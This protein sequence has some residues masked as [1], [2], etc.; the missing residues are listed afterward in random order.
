MLKTIRKILLKPERTIH[1]PPFVFEPSLEAADKNL[2]VLKAHNTSLETV[3][4]SS[5]FSVC[6]LGSEFRPVNDLQEIFK[7]HPKL[8]KGA[9]YPM[10]ELDEVKRRRRRHKT[11]KSLWS[12][13][14]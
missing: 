3:L 7:D 1:A 12:E 9:K 11:R 5:P 2:K 14:L 8:Q 4:Q 13:D 6:S 10:V